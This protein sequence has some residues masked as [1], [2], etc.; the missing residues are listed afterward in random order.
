MK[1]PSKQELIL[2]AIIQT[3]L[4]SR[5]PIGSLELQMKMTLGISPSTIRIYFK[6]LSDVGSLEQLH[7]SGGRVPTH[8]ALMG[9]WQEKLDP[10]HPLEI[11]N[12]D[13][14]KRSSHEHNLFCIVEKTANSPFKELVTVQNRFLI[15]V[16]DEH[17]VVLKFNAKVEQFL[18]RLFGCQMRELKDISAQVG[19]Y[20]L[21][22]KL[23][24]I[25]S[26]APILREGEREM[27]SIAQELQNEAFIQ[28]FQ[29][30]HFVESITDG[31][32]FDGFVPQGCMAIKQKAQLKDEDTT[33]DFFCFGRIESDFEEFFNQVKE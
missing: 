14:I 22:E 26:Q 33:V 13:K 1:K 24:A 32:Y 19:L 3:Y 21:H 7:V 6:K 16:F 11:K 23:S 12:I 20:E 28:R 9:Y 4:K 18:Q 27:Y 31:L 8:R 5:M 15:L 10:T 30:L 25:F 17:E 2:D 29:T